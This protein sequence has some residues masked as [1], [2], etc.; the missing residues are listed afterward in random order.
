MKIAIIGASTGQLPLCE[1]AK[2]MGLTTICFAWEDGAVCKDHVDKFY[3]ISIF[4]KEKILE[5]CK[6]E[7]INGVISNASDTLVETVAYISEQMGLNGNSYHVI[8]KIKNKHYVRSVTSDIINLKSIRNLKYDNLSE[9]PLYPCVIKPISG[10]AKVGVHYVKNQDEFRTAINYAKEVSADIMI[11]EYIC[12]REI[13]VESLSFNGAH[14]VVQITDKENSGSPH[15]VELSHHQP[16][17]LTPDLKNK[18]TD[19]VSKVLD[20]VN[21]K[22]GASHIEFIID[23]LEYIYLIEVN[24]RGG[25][26]EISNRLVSLSTD[27]DYL[28]GMIDVALGQFKIVDI[29]HIFYSGIYFL[30]AQTKDRLSFFEKSKNAEWLVDINIKNLNLQE[31][32]GNYDRNGYLIYQAN[33]KIDY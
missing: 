18:L 2:Q 27:F 12:G 3:P 25:G 4:E 13:S 26:D 24:P 19:V 1:K 7:K 6:E 5:I 8:Q 32:K 33:N 17:N 16:A 9:S 28:K 11:E 21:F 31:A 29:S 15:F 10:A 14:S 20:A 30:C 22:N 23:D